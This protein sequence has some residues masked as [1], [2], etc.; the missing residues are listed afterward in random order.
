MGSGK[1]ESVERSCCKEKRKKWGEKNWKW[2]YVKE[3]EKWFNVNGK[4]F[5]NKWRL[6]K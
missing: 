2:K 4:G 1:V 3:N 5:G 6:I